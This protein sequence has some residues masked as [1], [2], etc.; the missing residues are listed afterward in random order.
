MQY[1]TD[2]PYSIETG[3]SKWLH[4]DSFK[5]L[6]YCDCSF[7][8]FCRLFFFLFFLFKLISTGFK[9]N[10]LRFVNVL[11]QTLFANGFFEKFVVTRKEKQ[12]IETLMFTEFEFELNSQLLLFS[13]ILNNQFQRSHLTIDI[14]MVC[15][16]ITFSILHNI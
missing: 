2:F 7:L 6:C 15:M 8:N 11:A 16:A 5:V 1:F 3:R 13:F 10:I 9:L 14:K 4:L 12:A